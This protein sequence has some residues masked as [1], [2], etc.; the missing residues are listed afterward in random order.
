MED[1]DW[2]GLKKRNLYSALCPAFMI[3]LLLF[4]AGNL[5][6]QDQKA[7]RT[8]L[9]NP[10][11]EDWS[12]LRDT[13]KRADFWDPLKYISLGGDNR[14]LTLSAEIRYRGEGFRIRGTDEIPATRDSYFLQ[15]YLVGA[16]LHL[17]PRFRFFTEIQSGLI[18]GRLGAPRPTDR[19]DLDL[20]QGFFEW[21]QPLKGNQVFGLKLGRQELAIGSSRL[22][23]ASPGLNVKR[24]FDGAVLYYRSDSWQLYGAYAKLVSIKSGHFDD[25]PDNEQNFWGFSATRKS[26]RFKNGELG[27]YYLGLDRARAVYYQDQGRDLRHTLGVEWSGSGTRLELNYNAIFQWGSFR[28]ADARAWALS[29]E[30][31]YRLAGMPWKPRMALRF[32]IA[33]GDKDPN[34]PSLQSFNPFF[35]G[36]SYAGAVG[37]LGPTNLTDLT[38]SITFAVLSNLIMGVEAPSYWR[39]STAD[40]VYATDLRVLLPADV[41]EGKYVGTNPAY[42][43]I[44]QATRHIQLQG[45]I[46]RFLSSDFLKETF[47]SNGFGFYSATFKYRF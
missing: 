29:T 32:D 37:L 20:H 4:L 30:T 15:R 7:V 43:I 46:T 44:W 3:I 26:P 10:A 11:N 24:S 25:T 6:A 23:S 35:P 22:I 5:Q 2:P 41:G 36:N 1:A 31:G 38:P 28:D 47:V 33:S 17:G 12:L 21:R 8:Y 45:A 14:Y 27:F 19:N 34:D 18:S 42:I 16:D 13:S 39:T 40:G 9:P